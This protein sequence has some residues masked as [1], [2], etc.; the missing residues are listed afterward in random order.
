[1]KLVPARCAHSAHL[2]ILQLLFFSSVASTAPLW[3]SSF[4]LQSIPPDSCSGREGQSGG[5]EKYFILEHFLQI[6]EK[7][8]STKMLCVQVHGSTTMSRTLDTI[9]TA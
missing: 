4:F 6:R 5:S 1:M 3:G 7:L 2:E 9:L 8:N